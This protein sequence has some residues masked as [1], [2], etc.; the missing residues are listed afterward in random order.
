MILAQLGHTRGP[1]ALLIYFA[2]RLLFIGLHHFHR[3]VAPRVI[4]GPIIIDQCQPKTHM[5][6]HNLTVTV[7]LQPFSLISPFVWSRRGHDLASRNALVT[8]EGVTPVTGVRALR[9]RKAPVG[10]RSYPT[11]TSSHEEVAS[12]RFGTGT[13]AEHAPIYNGVTLI[14]RD[15]VRRTLCCC[16]RRNSPS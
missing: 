12:D 7:S 9:F 3:S 6:N 10:Y 4:L 14:I 16:F 1:L 5:A 8:R 11:V 13:S 15:Q 2:F